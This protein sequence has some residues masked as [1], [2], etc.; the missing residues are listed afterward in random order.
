MCVCANG[1]E[2]LVGTGRLVV[3]VM[4]VVCPAYLMVPLLDS[5]HTL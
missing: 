3:I 2:I 4:M 1:A 5:A